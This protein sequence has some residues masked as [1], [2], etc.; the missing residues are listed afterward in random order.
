MASGAPW[1]KDQ[2]IFEP[3]HTKLAAEVTDELA[4]PFQHLAQAARNAASRANV[5]MFEVFERPQRLFAEI[6]LGLKRGTYNKIF[7]LTGEGGILN[8]M[9]LRRVLP[10][11]A[12][13]IRPRFSSQTRSLHPAGPQQASRAGAAAPP[14]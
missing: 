12:G 3:F 14:P 6:G 10:I 4:A 8:Q 1:A 2:L 11:A 5:E 9:L 13:T 7:H